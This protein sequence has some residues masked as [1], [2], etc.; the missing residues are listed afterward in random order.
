[1]S[2]YDGYGSSS[3]AP[4][5][6][7]DNVEVKDTPSDELD[8]G[9]EPEAPPHDNVE[10]SRAKGWTTRTLIVTTLALALLNAHSLQSWATT[11]PPDWGGETIRAMAEAWYGRMVDAG[12]DQPRAAI[13]DAYEAKKS[14]TWGDLATRSGR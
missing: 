6:A 13:H 10:A 1:M 5:G 4:F 8:H 14:L 9:F 11:L 2:E 3:D 7:L 12:L